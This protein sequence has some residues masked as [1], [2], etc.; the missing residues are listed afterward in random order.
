[1]DSSNGMRRFGPSIG[2]VLALFGLFAAPTWADDDVAVGRRI[3][4]K[5]ILGNGAPL[6]AVRAGEVEVSGVAAACVNCHRRSGMGAVEGDI[7]IRPITGNYL[8]HIG[9]KNMATMDPRIGK[10]MN[11]AHDAYTDVTLVRAIR[12]GVNSDGAQMSPLMPRFTL[13]DADM[14]ALQAYLKQLSHEWSP[15]VTDKT[16]RFATVLTPGIEP[17][18]RKVFLDMLQAAVAMKNGSTAPGH[19]HM[20]SPAEMLGVTERNWILD[21]WELQ[22]EPAAWAAQLDEHQRRQPVFAILSGLSNGTWEP[23]AEFSERNRV[24]C[25]FPSIDLPPQASAGFYS[26]YFSRGVALEADVLATHLRTALKPQRPKRVV[27]VFRDEVVGRGGAEALGRA[28]AGSGI[29]VEDRVVAD[30]LA[31]AL[32]GIGGKDVVVLWLRPDD[33]AAIPSAAPSAAAVFLSGRMAHGER[34]PLS[35]L[36]RP[37]AKLLYPYQL[38]TKRDANLASFHTWMQVRQFPMIDEALQAEVFFALTYMTSTIAEMLDNLYGDYLLERAENMLSLQ[39]TTRSVDETRMR[40]VAGR[41]GAMIAHYGVQAVPEGIH[42]DTLELI[43]SV[44][45]AQTGMSIYPHLGLAPGQR[46]ASKGAYIARFAPT[47]DDDLV[48]ESDW[49]VP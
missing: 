20:V 22:G 7:Q 33:I 15:G 37:K 6:T 18:R 45:N 11:Q 9:H 32:H 29:L 26:V 44:R 2:L 10:R 4:L 1:M 12:E 3:Y 47:R 17:A 38:P 28:L 25:W 49:I 14:Q 31:S 8:F 19:R 46:F 5:G 41:S 39:E 35:A 13:G 21:V 24:P 36:W 43:T 48:L 30:T 23:V 27:Q 16:I 40:A 34:A 42:R